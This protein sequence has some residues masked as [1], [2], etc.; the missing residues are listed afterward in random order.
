MSQ[1]TQP[2][3]PKVTRLPL[4]GAY[5]N[6]DG[7][8][9]TKDQRYLNMFPEARKVEQLDNTKLAIHKRP[10]LTLYRNFGAGEGRG[11][12]NLNGQ[13]Y[14]AIGNKVYKDDGVPTAKITLTNSTG[15]LGIILANSSPWQ[16]SFYL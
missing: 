4:F 11:I 16:L 15:P 12:A 5:S 10:G 2:G 13:Y 6:R 3:K 7:A 9:A 8:V 1:P 14:V